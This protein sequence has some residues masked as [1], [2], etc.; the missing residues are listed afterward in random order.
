MKKNRAA[1]LLSAMIFACGI[2]GCS[3]EKAGTVSVSSVKETVQRSSSE[4]ENA[5][6]DNVVNGVAT[7]TI[8]GG[9]AGTSDD[10]V[11][12]P[13][14]GSAIIDQNFDDGG[15]GHFCIY[16]NGGSCKISNENNELV[17]DIQRCGDVDYG[18][19]VYYDGFKLDKGAVY[20]L[21][22]DLASTIDRKVACRIQINGGD[23]HAYFEQTMKA[24]SEMKHFEQE[25]TMEEDSDPAPRFCFNMGYMDDMSEDPGDHAVRIDNVRLVAKD[26]SG[27]TAG[28][29]LPSYPDAVT[30]QI[31]FR[32]DDVKSVVVRN[33]ED[34]G[35][36]SLINDKTGKV[37]YKGELGKL[38]YDQAAQ[39]Q[40]R[41][42]DFSDYRTRGIYHIHVTTASAVQ[43]TPPFEI[44]NDIYDEMFR[45]TLRMLYL[46]RCGMKVKS[47]DGS[48]SHDSCHTKKAL[49]YGTSKVIDVSGG[50]HDA[51]DYGRYVVSGAK[52][53]ADLL[54]AYED[55]GVKSDDLGI[56]E[57]GNRIPDIL[58]E[59]RYELDWMLK[60]QDEET[61]GVYHKVSCKVFP[62]TVGPEDETDQL[63]VAP[64]STAATGD[65]A[66]VMAKASVVF[67]Q[68]DPAFSE[69]AYA[70]AKKAFEY[71]RDKKDTAGF[72]NPEDIVTGEYP[73]HGTEDE[74]L[75]AAVE[76][77]LAGDKD[78][79]KSIRERWDPDIMKAG[80]GWAKMTGYACTDLIRKAGSEM[81][82]V[83]G[84]MKK[85][86]LTDADALLE[87]T[88]K[89]AYGCSLGKDFSWGS[90]MT[91][92]NNGILLEIASEITGEEKYKTAAHEQIGYLLGEN[93]LGYCFVT[94]YG[95]LS[96]INPHHRPSQLAGS[97]MKGM[98]VGGPNKNLED[99]YAKAVLDGQ[100][101]GMCYVDNAQSYSTNEVAIYW[102][103]P[104]I[105]L[106]AGK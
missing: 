55:Y 25:F 69:K 79:A 8:T 80:F 44:G 22:F 6:D 68:I 16:N 70:A 88:E 93:P 3:A 43:D 19:Q 27:A 76:L 102:N 24:G 51:G 40:V 56:P 29:G 105:Y 2:A 28:A 54:W 90:N 71:V 73:D 96:P 103:S 46:Q 75:W 82:D 11:A 33:A 36:Y 26:V 58:D 47:Q 1:A 63:I 9:E 41:V 95:T 83:T 67:R 91:V 100:P 31:G 38:Q 78:C 30:S 59:A 53:V 81:D 99:P 74:I 86:L 17:V 32:P 34:G 61:G 64:V 84:T 62:E 104:L 45:D 52:T 13:E 106:L 48:F 94:G 65:F 89:S 39:K 57:S 23:Y 77:Y 7:G 85:M 4:K 14:P 42:G 15:N 60:M 21:S 72:T 37:V 18:N 10:S 49:I 5:T 20:V 35:S 98:L 50:W 12:L 92:A 87:Q 97:A 101:A 66:A